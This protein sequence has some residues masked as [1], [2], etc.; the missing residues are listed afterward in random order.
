MNEVPH[1][2]EPVKI[3]IKDV[4]Q[5]IDLTVPARPDLGNDMRQGPAGPGPKP[6]DEK[7]KL[8]I[9]KTKERMTP[10]RAGVT[11]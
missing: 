5:A 7:I 4:Y 10:W 2:E 3:L 11:K 8:P 9:R 6:D 1:G